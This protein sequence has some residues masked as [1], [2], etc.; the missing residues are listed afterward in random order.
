MRRF[1]AMLLT[2]IMLTA[3]NSITQ[4]AEHQHQAPAPA[5]AG[6]EQAQKGVTILTGA[7]NPEGNVLLWQFLPG[8]VV[9][10]AGEP[11]TFRNESPEAHT[12]TILAGQ[13]MES[14]TEELAMTPS[15]AS[16]GSYDGN[17][18]FNSGVIF[19]GQQYTVT[20]TK[21]GV[22]E[23]VCL[24]HYPMMQGRLIV[25]PADAQVP[26]N[27]H[28]DT[29]AALIQAY[30]RVAQLAAHQ[31]Q[32]AQVIVNQDGTRTYEVYM[33]A[34]ADSAFAV[35][36]LPGNLRIKEGDTVKWIPGSMLG[37]TVGM[38]VPADFQLFG[39]EGPILENMAPAGGPTFDGTGTVRSGVLE[40]G[41][42]FS[43][44]FTKAGTY[45]VKDYLAAAFGVNITG[46]ITVVPG[47]S[48][49]VSLGGKLVAGRLESGS[50]YVSL[51][52]AAEALGATLTTNS[53][54]VTTLTYGTGAYARSGDSNLYVNGTPIYSTFSSSD[55]TY[56]SALALALAL[57][58]DIQFDADSDLMT[59]TI[60]AAK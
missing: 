39:E 1:A 9:V 57:D 51:T 35:A 14:M 31:E 56:L 18:F 22:Y 26:E 30:Q 37:G 7:L 43:L 24:P 33:G 47:D 20:F 2:A 34:G 32:Q 16:G 54:G 19:P 44:T 27:L 12:A 42:S 48:V 21:P 53:Q 60:P 29:E 8:T 36:Y 49:D 10:K 38:N 11:V 40:P 59:L 45:E 28:H 15:V 46:T 6:E 4:A 17:G 55:T 50:I 5:A 52:D 13:S 41:A 25:L 58:A 23:Y 3:A